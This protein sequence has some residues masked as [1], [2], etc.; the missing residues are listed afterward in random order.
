ML[1]VSN[2]VTHR[3]DRAGPAATPALELRVEPGPGD[4]AG[5]ARV[6]ARRRWDPPRAVRLAAALLGLAAI[7]TYLV[8]ALLRLT[9]PFPPR[10]PGKQ[11][12]RRGAADPQRPPALYGAG[13]RL[14][15]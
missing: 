9:Y 13:G 2:P 14:R 11:L 8:T 7:A 3:A 10:V 6:P 5:R 1:S 4:A 12:A 15:A